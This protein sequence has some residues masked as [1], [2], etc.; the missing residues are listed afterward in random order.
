MNAL[1]LVGGLG[2]RLKNK[3]PH[4][5]KPMAPIGDKPFLELLMKR[6]NDHGFK[7]IIL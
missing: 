7:K 6:L 2:S 4:L 1:I 3:V 5:P